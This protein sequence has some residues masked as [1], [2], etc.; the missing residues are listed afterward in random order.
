MYLI[1]DA[2]NEKLHLLWCVFVLAL[3]FPVE[4]SEL[5]TEF[6]CNCGDSMKMKRSSGQ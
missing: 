2:T 5:K 3:S 1:L 4:E 6:V